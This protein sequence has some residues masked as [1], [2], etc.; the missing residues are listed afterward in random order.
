MSTLVP[1]SQLPPNQPS[2]YTPSGA[3]TNTLAIVSLVSGIFSVF[4]HFIIPGVGGG[5][6]ALVAIITGFLARGEIRRGGQQGMWMATVGIILGILHLAVI[7][8]IFVVLILAVFV[9]GGIALLHR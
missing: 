4:G 7:A 9:F 6:L 2:T 8:L 5:T 3:S 1:V